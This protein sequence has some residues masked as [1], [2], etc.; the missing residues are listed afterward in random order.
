MSWTSTL[1]SLPNMGIIQLLLLQELFWLNIFL[2]SFWKF[3]KICTY[4]KEFKCH[5]LDEAIPKLN[6]ICYKRKPHPATRNRL[7]FWVDSQKTH[8][9]PTQTLQL[10]PSTI[11]FPPQPDSKT[12]HTYVIEHGEEWARAQLEASPLLSSVN[13]AGRCY[14]CFQRRKV[15][16][17]LIQLWAAVVTCL[18]D[19]PSGAILA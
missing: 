3:P 13:S 12:P 2:F 8:L 1:T 11:V 19:M 10:I 15:A 4:E 18:E 6:I 5:I 7:H 17:G 16:I 14:I 9:D